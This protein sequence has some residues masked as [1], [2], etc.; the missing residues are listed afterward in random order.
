MGDAIHA[1]GTPVETWFYDAGGRRLRAPGFSLADYSFQLIPRPELNQ[2][3]ARA[4][5]VE[6]IYLG[7]KVVAFEEHTDHVR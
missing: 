1:I 3:L 2:L 7:A 6:N 4:V 5:G